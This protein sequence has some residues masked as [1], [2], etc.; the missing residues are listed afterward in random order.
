MSFL[1]STTFALRTAVRASALRQ[2][3][4]LFSTT[5]IQQKGP[6][7]AAKDTLKSVDRAV[8]DAAVAGIDKGVEIKD[9]AAAAAGIETS[10]AEAKTS[11]VAGEAKGKASEVAG[12]AKGK[13][14]ELSGKA[15]GTAEEIKR[16]MS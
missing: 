2:S 16:K 9:K 1:S 6:V 14:A 4:R 5:L 11:E 8:S 10:K 3:P 13:A 15:K 12:E 7:D